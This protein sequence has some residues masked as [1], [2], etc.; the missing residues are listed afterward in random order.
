[1]PTR[2]SDL[3]SWVNR[4]GEH[5]TLLEPYISVNKLDSHHEQG[6]LGPALADALEANYGTNNV[7]V[8][9]VGGAYKASLLD[10]FF[11]DGTTAVAITEGKNL[12][13]LA[14]SQCPSSKVVV[15]G[16]RYL[17]LPSDPS[18]CFSSNLT[19]S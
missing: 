13:A 4:G 16:Y 10:N 1:M 11:T 17:T 7:W 3:G 8:Q 9:G 12:L 2:H 18:F 14:N 15:G 19:L 5:V 6:T